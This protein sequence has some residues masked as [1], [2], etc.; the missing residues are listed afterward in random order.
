MNTNRQN[1][2]TTNSNAPPIKAMD[3]KQQADL[4][5]L[6]N[7]LV[8]VA[9]QRDKQAFAYLFSWFAPKI[10]G[11]A[12]K[13]LGSEAQAMEVVQETMSKVWNKA[14]LFDKN[15]GAA[16]TWVYTIM[17]NV[18]FDLLRKQQTRKED[19][20]SDDL[21][22]LVEAQSAE[23]NDDEYSDH[24]EKKLIADHIQSLPQA[25]QDI[26]KGLYFHELSQEQLA[27]QLDI[28]LGTV[29]SRLRLAMAKLKNQLG[30]NHD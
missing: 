21:W 19:H 16:T 13:Q 20:L 11:I 4:E 5:Q 25:Q 2:V 18:S 24:I 29:K 23:D 14:H 30:G 12:I 6:K 17:R 10:K 15:K 8:N 1:I 26:I 27:K 22:P 7:C 3:D 28:P 9:T